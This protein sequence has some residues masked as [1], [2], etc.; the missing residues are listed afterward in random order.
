MFKSH[1]LR[2]TPKQTV[3]SSL[4]HGDQS[5]TNLTTTYSKLMA[6]GK[7]VHEMQIHQVKP[8][9]VKEYIA[10]TS[11]EYPRLHQDAKYLVKLFG[12]WQTQ[13][14]ALDQFVHIWEYQNYPGFKQTFDILQ[15]DTKYQQFV[16]KLRPLLVKRENHLMQ[17]FAYWSGIEK[18]QPGGIYELRSYKL[19]PGRMLEWEQEWKK[20]IDA[21]RKYVE[22]VG[23]WFNQ[24]GDL[25][26]VHHMWHYPDLQ[27]RKE[28]REKAWEVKGWAE[29][30]VKT[31]KLI[32]SMQAHILT[33][34]PFSPKP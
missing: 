26:Y 14:G 20:G 13:V 15:E 9:K 17:E 22:P 5:Q 4:L 12:S 11:G 6:R 3:L 24:L 18:L 28:L 30:V 8:D 1:L 10:L 2:N 23:A 7:F 29:T 27:Q 33:S 31:V 25:N 16:D 34:L 21:R 19:Q 32:D